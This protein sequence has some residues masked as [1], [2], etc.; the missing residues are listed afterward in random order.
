MPDS[1]LRP[2]DSRTPYGCLTFAVQFAVGPVMASG[3]VQPV[4]A[5]GALEAGLV[6]A[7]G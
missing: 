5:N 2:A 3:R 4:L 1:E 6:P 7:L